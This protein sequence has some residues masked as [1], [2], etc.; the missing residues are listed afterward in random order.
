MRLSDVDGRLFYQK[1]PAKI[2]FLERLHAEAGEFVSAFVFRM[3]GMAL[4]PVPL[5]L[6]ALVGG[7]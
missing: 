5:D 2:G 3:A 4:D 1:R 6:V 7:V